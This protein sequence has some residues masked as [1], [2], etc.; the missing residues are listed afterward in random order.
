MHTTMKRARHRTAAAP[1]P[2]ALA[3]AT[4]LKPSLKPTLTTC[5]ALSSASSSLAATFATASLATASLASFSPAA[6]ADDAHDTTSFAATVTTSS[7]AP[8]RRAVTTPSVGLPELLRLELPFEQEQVTVFVSL[9]SLRAR[10]GA[11]DGGLDQTGGP[12][13]LREL[14][15]DNQAEID[16]AAIRKLLAGARQPLVLRAGDLQ[17]LCA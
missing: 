15:R 12:I 3:A 1:A 9:A 10:F 14:Y 17:D 13:G 11:A 16:A 8:P 6:F 5:S 4:R 7:P 2:S